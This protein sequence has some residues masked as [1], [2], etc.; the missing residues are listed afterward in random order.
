LEDAGHSVY[1]ADPTGPAL[2]LGK[3]GNCI[4]VVWSP[5][6]VASLHVYEDARVALSLGILVQVFTG[7]FEL[8]TLPPV[9][10]AQPLISITNGEQIGCALIEIER[11]LKFSRNLSDSMKKRQSL[12]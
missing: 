10:R 3:R 11:K 12:Q 8:S 7:E 4:I 6:A 1:S 5:A 2:R 9:F